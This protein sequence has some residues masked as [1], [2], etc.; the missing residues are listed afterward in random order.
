VPSCQTGIN[1]VYNL[2]DRDGFHHCVFEI[3]IVTGPSTPWEKRDNGE[4]RQAQYPI[5]HG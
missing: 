3:V 5:H 4:D 2:F 1:G